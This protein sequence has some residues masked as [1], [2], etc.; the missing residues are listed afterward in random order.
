M[1]SGEFTIEAGDSIAS[2]PL[3]ET[4]T[5]ESTVKLPAHYTPDTAFMDVLADPEAKEALMPLIRKAMKIFIPEQEQNQTDAAR[6]AIS[7]EMNA[8]MMNYVPLRGVFSFGDGSIDPKE[9]ENLL[10]KLNK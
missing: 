3:K 1:E 10:E 7:E 6:E 2:L 9:V 5:V 4:V 8:A